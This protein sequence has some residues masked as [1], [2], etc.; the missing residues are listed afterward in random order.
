MENY[1]IAL[2]QKIETHNATLI[3]D[4]DKMIKD[5]GDDED[6]LVVINNKLNDIKNE[7]AEIKNGLIVKNNN[8]SLINKMITNN[9]NA[10]S[11]INKKMNKA[12]KSIN[13]DD[14]KNNVSN[15]KYIIKIIVDNE[16]NIYYVKNFNMA[17]KILNLNW[18]TCDK[19]YKKHYKNGEYDHIKI[20]DN[21]CNNI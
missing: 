1:Y 16:E 5:I 20:Y 2:T 11:E 13:I 15:A 7:E 21:I 6:A 14:Y 10:I 9:E 19:I 8:L 12:D 18:S 4:R 3:N 17:S